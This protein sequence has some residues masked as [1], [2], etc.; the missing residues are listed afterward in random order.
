MPVYPAAMILEA[1]L[2]T[3]AV[4]AY[5]TDQFD[6]GTQIVTLNGVN[7]TKFHITIFPGNTLEIDAELTQKRSNIWRFN[8]KAFVEDQ[9]VVE[10][11]LGIAVL[12]RAELF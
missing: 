1:M 2:Q 7:K 3:C 9:V 11:G 6:P 8:V 10:S 12:D 4:L 5:A